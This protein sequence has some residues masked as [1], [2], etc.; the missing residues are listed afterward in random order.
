MAPSLVLDL[1]LFGSVFHQPGKAG[2]ERE[3]VLKGLVSKRKEE[4]GKEAG[5]LNESRRAR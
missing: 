3:R 2:L 4:Y 5:S 1:L